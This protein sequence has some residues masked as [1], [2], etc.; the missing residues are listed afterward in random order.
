M[1][2]CANLPKQRGNPQFF[3]QHKGLIPIPNNLTLKL[4]NYH[5]SIS[6]VY[7]TLKQFMANF[8]PLMFS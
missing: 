8:L 7:V 3:K 2:I 4:Y 5:E 1:L 6:A